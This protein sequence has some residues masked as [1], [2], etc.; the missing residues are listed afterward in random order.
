[1]IECHKEISLTLGLQ[2]ESLELSMGMSSDY[3]HAVNFRA[4]FK[5]I[6][7][8]NYYLFIF[9]FFTLLLKLLRL[10]LEAQTLESEALF[11]GRGLQSINLLVVDKVHLLKYL[12]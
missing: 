1:M 9:F 11:L 6:L 10:S 3:E 12:C 8:K 5:K 2:R 4:Y 7:L